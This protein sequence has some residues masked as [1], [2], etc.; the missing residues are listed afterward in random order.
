MKKLLTKIIIMTFRGLIYGTALQVFFLSMMLAK[1]SEA[2]NIKSVRDAKISIELKDANIKEC[3][4]EIEKKTDYH[5]SYDHF[6]IDANVKINFKSKKK[7]VS[8][9]LLEISKEGKIKFMQV[10]NNINV[11]KLE[12]P[13]QESQLEVIIQ[14]I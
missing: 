7:Y 11:Q 2:Q 3:F 1:G 4:E 8:D 9:L 12:N 6:L 5:F 14:G 10:N 13:N